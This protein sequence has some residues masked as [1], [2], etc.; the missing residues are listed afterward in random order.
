MA[1]TLI[2]I[3]VVTSIIIKTFLIKKYPKI[4]MLMDLLFRYIPKIAYY[5]LYV[6]N[7]NI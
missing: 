4:F 7:L 1:P 3:K 2:I 5:T 6:S